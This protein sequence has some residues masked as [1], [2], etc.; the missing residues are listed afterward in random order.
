MIYISKNSVPTWLSQYLIKSVNEG[1]KPRKWGIVFSFWYDISNINRYCRGNFQHSWVSFG[2][3]RRGSRKGG[4]GWKYQKM[5]T[6][7]K[8][9]LKQVLDSVYTRQ[10]FA[11]WPYSLHIVLI[12]TWKNFC[13]IKFETSSFFWELLPK[14]FLK[15]SKTIK[16]WLNEM[17]Q[18]FKNYWI[19][20]TFKYIMK[21]N[22]MQ[23][24]WKH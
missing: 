15:W 3:V 19:F 1:V 20:Y 2:G 4:G 18:G 16:Y 6:N 8:L 11:I 14:N 22:M 7:A 21:L 9:L 13:Q 17:Y 24:L 12:M 5:P 23:R 10:P